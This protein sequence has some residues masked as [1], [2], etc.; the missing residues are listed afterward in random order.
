MLINQH[1]HGIAAAYAPVLHLRRRADDGVFATRWVPE[2]RRTSRDLLILVDE[3]V[4]SVTSSDLDP[5]RIFR[6]V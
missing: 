5:P 2:S 4:V 6:T 1:I 3:A